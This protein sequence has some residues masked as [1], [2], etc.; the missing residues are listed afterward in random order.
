[1]F[2][3]A[4]FTCNVLNPS[5]FDNPIHTQNEEYTATNAQPLFLTHRIYANCRLRSI[6]HNNFSNDIRRAHA[7]MTINSVTYDYRRYT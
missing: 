4:R 7:Y 2:D 6:A 3:P 1:M 5:M